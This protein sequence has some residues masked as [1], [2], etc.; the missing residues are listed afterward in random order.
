MLKRHP[1]AAL[2]FVWACDAAGLAI[3]VWSLGQ[4]RVVP[5]AEWG[6]FAVWAA[7]LCVSHLRGVVHFVGLNVNAGWQGAVDYAAAMILPLP[8]FCLAVGLRFLLA[9]AMRIRRQHPEPWL[10]PDFNAANILLNAT[11]AVTVGAWLTRSAGES[12]LVSALSLLATAATFIL[13][14][15]ALTTALLALDQRKPWRKVGSLDQDVL[16]SD[17]IMVTAGA[18]MAHIYRSNPYL[19]VITFL[20]LL[21]LHK[22]LV[23][24]NEAKLAYVDGKTGIY[25]YR[26]FDESLAELF[27]KSLQSK[28]PLALVFGDMDHLRDIN[29][30]HGHMV[31][32]QAIAAVARAFLN[33]GGPEAVACRFGGEEFVLVLPGYTKAEAAAVAE[34]VRQSVAETAIPLDSGEM[35]RVTISLGAAAFPE[36]A[37]AVEDLIKAAD[38]AVY[39]AK[40]SGRNRVCTYRICKVALKA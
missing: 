38:A 3:A 22:T 28:R 31:G 20:L 26:H 37:G 13:V 10:G 23:R 35:L 25:N 12:H 24:I 2:C 29:N 4:L 30:T 36:D 39:D 32:D 8:L 7:V 5:A 14:Q 6:S 16:I 18:L 33:K 27:R 17:G 11:A 34:L 9:V 15:I 40:Q 19:M 1:L 21:F